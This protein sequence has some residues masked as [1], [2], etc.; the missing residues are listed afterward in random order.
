[1]IGTCQ[2][3][4]YSKL[5]EDLR[6]RMCKRY[7]P[8]PNFVPTP[9]GMQQVTAWPAVSP[10]DVCGEFKPRL[11]IDI[12]DLR[13]MNGATDHADGARCSSCGALMSGAHDAH[14]ATKGT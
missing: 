4:D 5:T 7:P 6:V 8:V 1:M 3:C 9:Q 14:C 12:T 11:S 10:S 13:N 2:N